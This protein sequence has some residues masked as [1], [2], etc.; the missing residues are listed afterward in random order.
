MLSKVLNFYFTR[1]VSGEKMLKNDYFISKSAI[2]NAPKM[3]EAIPFV[4]KNARLILLKSL[5]FTK[6]C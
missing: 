6:R 2:T 3:T 4:V 5:C 1:L